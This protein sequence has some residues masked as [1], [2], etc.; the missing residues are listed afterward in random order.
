MKVG[1]GTRRCVMAL[2]AA[3]R[4]HTSDGGLVERQHVGQKD[5]EGAADCLMLLF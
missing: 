1:V 4:G 3:R 2:P 5:A